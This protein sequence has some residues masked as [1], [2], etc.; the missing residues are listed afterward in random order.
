MITSREFLCLLEDR[1]GSAAPT[2]EELRD[3]MQREE[4]AFK[5]KEV[6]GFVIT[7]YLDT[8]DVALLAS[9]FNVNLCR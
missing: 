5:S 7:A 3:V 6:D 4:V 9:C 2:Y 8:S 1:V